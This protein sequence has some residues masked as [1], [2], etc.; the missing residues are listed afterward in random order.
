MRGPVRPAPAILILCLA[1]SAARSMEPAPD[2]TP[3][4]PKPFALT[5]DHPPEL[6]RPEKFWG[7]PMPGNPQAE[8]RAAE[9][10]VEAL[11]TGHESARQER[12][13]RL[14]R[15][16]ADNDTRLAETILSGGAPADG[17]LPLPAP[18]DFVARFRGSHLHYFVTVERGVTPLML[19]AGLGH[20]EM[21]ALLVARG[22][23]PDARTKRH[24]TFALWLAGKGKHVRVMQMLLGVA[25]DSEAAR[26]LVEVDLAKQTA[27]LLRD[28]VEVRSVPISSGRRSFATPTGEYVV[29]DKHRKWRSTIYPAEMP[30]FMRLSCGDFGFHAGH[31]PGYPAS[32]GCIRL[33]RPDAETMFKDVPVGTRVVIK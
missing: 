12:L 3:F 8:A 1:A 32:H 5:P 25:P 23:S 13:M 7:E 11:T 17:A 20:A 26:L 2:H 22:A 10:I 19:A 31:L 16:V 27:N 9:A 28:G 30:F 29:T 14:F 33:K 6:P 4:A 24:R 21:V 18:E 15:A